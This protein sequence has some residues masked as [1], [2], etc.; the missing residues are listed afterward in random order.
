MF[1][2]DLL[3]VVDAPAIVGAHAVAGAHAI[4][5][6]TALPGVPT[7]AITSMLLFAFLLLFAPL[8]LLRPCCADMLTFLLLLAR[9][10]A[11]VPDVAWVHDVA[12]M[13]MVS[14]SFA[15]ATAPCYDDIHNMHGAQDVACRL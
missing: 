14:C 1:F 10:V 3:A 4:A 6:G 13:M 9:S 7:V 11:G 8:Q 12:E 5:G 15:S 2:A